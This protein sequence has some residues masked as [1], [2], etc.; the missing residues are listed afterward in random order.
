MAPGADR[1]AR[2][3]LLPRP[4]RR[5][6]SATTCSPRPATSTSPGARP[7]RS[8]S[9]TGPTRPCDRRPARPPRRRARRSRTSRSTVTTGTIDLLGI[10]SASAGAELGDQH[11]PAARARGRGARRDDRRHRRPP[12]AVERRAAG[13]AAA[14]TR[15]R[16]AIPV[17]GTGHERAGP[18][19]VLRYVQ[20]TREPLVVGDA[21]RDDRFARDPYFADVSC[22]SLLAV[23]DPQPRRAAGGAA[24]GEPPHPRR[25]HRRAAR[26]ASSSSPGS[27]P[28][29]STTPSATPSTAGSPT[30]RRRC[31]AWPHAG[32]P[33]DRARHA[34]F[35]AVRREVGE[36]LGADATHRPSRYAQADGATVVSVAQWEAATPGRPRSGALF[37]SRATACPRGLRT[38]R[39]ARMDELRGT[40][41]A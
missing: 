13:L 6:R 10:L 8:T 33:R 36:V 37:P 16:R 18:M 38:G 14:R 23:P 17:S 32:R 1:R 39:P 7:P 20:R 2:G 29:R 34:V 26:R 27:S 5:A 28:S 41:P 9:S 31:G 35:A 30:S 4:R 22:C 24:A 25:V 3:P 21:A 15:Q 12:A 19:S 40:R 11:R